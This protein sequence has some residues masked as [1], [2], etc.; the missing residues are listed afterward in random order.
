MKNHILPE[1]LVVVITLSYGKRFRGI[2]NTSRA[3]SYQAGV[4]DAC[5]TSIR[6]VAVNEK[7]LSLKLEKDQS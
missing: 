4:F 3:G 6:T 1:S 5:I 2:V 7:P